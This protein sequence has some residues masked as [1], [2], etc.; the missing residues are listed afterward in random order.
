MSVQHKSDEKSYG[1]LKPDPKMVFL[2][3]EA[4][5][6]ED[7]SWPIEIGVAWVN[8]DFSIGS[9]SHLIRPHESWPLDLWNFDSEKIHKTRMSLLS[10]A[11]P[12]AEVAT[13][14]NDFLQEKVLVSDNPAYESAWLYRLLSVDNIDTFFGQH[15]EVDTSEVR[16]SVVAEHL[17][18]RIK[19]I[20]YDVMNEEL[21]FERCFRWMQLTE[22]E[23]NTV[24][25]PHKAGPDAMLMA[26]QWRDVMLMA[27]SGY[28]G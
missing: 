2:D 13:W 24:P 21:G 6:L 22:G 25:V 9:Q 7:D 11:R 15:L 12:A 4:S 18:H 26:G 1:L 5:G 16:R 14:A 23:D 20:F 28:L 10:A 3:F 17:E 8:E 27:N 19:H